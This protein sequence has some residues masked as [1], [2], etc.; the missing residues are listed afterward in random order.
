M[1]FASRSLYLASEAVTHNHLGRVGRG[2]LIAVHVPKNRQFDIGIYPQGFKCRFKPG[3]DLYSEV[4]GVL[5]VP[6][7]AAVSGAVADQKRQ[8]GGK[9]G[10]ITD[11][12]EVV[13]CSIA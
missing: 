13:V 3:S 5:R 8:D 1:S 6:I 2:Q 11:L 7:G 4:T 12:T 10:K 9:F